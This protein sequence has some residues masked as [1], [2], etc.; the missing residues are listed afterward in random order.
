MIDKTKDKALQYYRNAWKTQD[1]HEEVYSQ[2]V[3][4]YAPMKVFK[5]KE[6]VLATLKNWFMLLHDVSE[7]SYITHGEQAVMLSRLAL[8]NS[9]GSIYYLWEYVYFQFN[10][11]GQIKLYRPIFDSG[12]ATYELLGFDIAA[13]CA[14]ARKLAD[15]Q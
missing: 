12:K 13:R 11:N 7:V 10:A 9:G 14:E 1:L 8:N 2:D 4:F 3:E 5:G 6:V 15:R